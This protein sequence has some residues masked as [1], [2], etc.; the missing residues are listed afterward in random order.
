MRER[1]AA[2]GAS[3]NIE[4]ARDQGTRLTLRWPARRPRPE[5]TG[6]GRPGAE[7]EA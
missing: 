2:V 1:A 3:L 7:G 5:L 6:R 4:S